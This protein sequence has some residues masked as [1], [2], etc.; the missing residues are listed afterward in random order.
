MKIF[1]AIKSLFSAPLAAKEDVQAQRAQQPKREQLI[2]KQTTSPL[3]AGSL[4]SSRKK[5]TSI[6]TPRVI[7]STQE[8]DR[9]ALDTWRANSDLVTGLRFVATMQLRT[10]LRVLKRHGELH[11]NGNTTPPQIAEEMWEGI[12]LAK[13]K[14]FSELGIQMPEFGE[15]SMATEIGPIKGGIGP[16]LAFLCAIRTCV[17]AHEPI[18]VRVEKLKAV[19]AEPDFTSFVRRH[20]GANTIIDRFF[21]LFL[22]T[23]PKL[24]DASVT[25]LRRKQ[26][27]T[28]AK[29]SAASDDSLL[30]ISGIGPAKLKALRAYC[31]KYMDS[32][33]EKRLDFVMH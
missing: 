24:P 17:E 14:S 28:P 30:S 1:S 31:D 18:E 9:K 5:S 23:I 3:T 25:E 21:P 20:G 15:G 11:T 27:T 32:P 12:W 29:L 13:T 26:L 7:S 22:S 8:S 4:D 16:Y 19:L 6:T 2:N 33:N 10:P